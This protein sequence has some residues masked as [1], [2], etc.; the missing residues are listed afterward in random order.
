MT[1]TTAKTTAAMTGG[2][3]DTGTTGAAT[4]GSGETAAAAKSGWLS[5]VKD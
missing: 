1:G 3:E 4:S 2:T 5:P